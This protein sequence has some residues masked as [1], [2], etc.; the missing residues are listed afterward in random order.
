MFIVY[1]FLFIVVADAWNTKVSKMLVCGLYLL[2]QIFYH[3]PSQAKDT[4]L[5]SQSTQL[6]CWRKFLFNR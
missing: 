4:E 1:G 6:I 2:A 5:F 3:G